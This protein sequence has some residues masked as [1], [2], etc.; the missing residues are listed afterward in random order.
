MPGLSRLYNAD[1]ICAER[2]ERAERAMRIKSDDDISVAAV[3]KALSDPIRWSIVRQMSATEELACTTLECTLPISKSTISYHINALHHAS[4][5]EVRRE[6]RFFFYR[7]RRDVLAMALQK[8]G[9]DLSL[10][11]TAD[12]P[13]LVDA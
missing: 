4:L 10:A 11:P 5:V 12:G 7:L 2:N 8:I 3:M 6:G 1:L 13:H 9:D